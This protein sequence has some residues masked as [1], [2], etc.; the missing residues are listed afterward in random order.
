[1]IRRCGI[2]FRFVYI[3]VGFCHVSLVSRCRHVCDLAGVVY[4]RCHICCELT[5][6]SVGV[7]A[8]CTLMYD[9]V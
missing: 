2:L 3:T 1:M 9:F 8:Y 4:V 5:V 7:T 6:N